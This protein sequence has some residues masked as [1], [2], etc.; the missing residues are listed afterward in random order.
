MN[1]KT[2]AVAMIFLFGN[3]SLLADIITLTPSKDNTIFSKND[4]ASNALGMLFTSTT[5]QGNTRRALL[6]FDVTSQIPT[7]STV[8]SASLMLNLSEAASGSG[9]LEHE[10]HRLLQDWGEGSSYATN[11]NGAAATPGDVTWASRFFPDT[12]WSTPGGDFVATPSA[13]AL[14]SETLAPV[15]WGSTP[16][17]VA[18][19]QA[20]LDSPGNN[21]G[22]I[23]LG[24][25]VQLGAARK[26]VNRENPD[27]ALRPVLTIEFTPPSYPDTVVPTLSGLGLA[28]LVLLM[29]GA[30]FVG[31]GVRSSNDVYIK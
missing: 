10:L 30:G 11:G 12:P 22:W 14:V 29:L 31:L 28:I 13:S 15:T 18:D 7:D 9:T 6:A 5:S 1:S 8:T 2:F 25:E 24:D 3:T 16:T 26:L 4:D 19:V 20:W 27:P 17:M 21:Y 23:L